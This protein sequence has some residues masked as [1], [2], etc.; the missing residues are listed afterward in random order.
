MTL[1]PLKRGVSRQFPAK[2]PTDLNQIL[3]G[4][5]D[6]KVHFAGGP[7]HV[8]LSRIGSRPRVFQRAIGEV[9]TLPLTFPNGGSKSE[10]VV[11]VNK[12]QVQSN[13]VCYEVSWYENF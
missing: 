7:A 11:F 6:Q 9:R 2:S 8:Q 5:K 13:K 3:H 12:I 1:K 4:A 10:F